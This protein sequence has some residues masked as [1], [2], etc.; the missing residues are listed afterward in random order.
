MMKYFLDIS[1][2]KRNKNFGLLYSGQFISFIG[3]KI[4]DVALPYQIY[5]QTHSTLMVGLLSL[6]QLVPLLFTALIGGVLADRYHRR[7]LL[8]ASETILCIGSLTLAWNA[9]LHSPQ[10]WV[11]FIVS[12]LMSAFNGLHRPALESML[13]QIVRKEDYISLSALRSFQGNVGMIGGPAIGGLLIA[14][15]GI[16]V[17]YLTDVLSFAFSLGSLL[18]MTEIPKPA[19]KRDESTWAALKQGC[20]FAISHQAILGSYIVDIIAMIFGMPMALFP[21]IAL[22]FGGAQALGFLYTAPAIG[23]L[24]ISFFSGWA[25]TIKHHGI[26]I[27]VA[28]SLWGIAIIFFGLANNFWLAIFFLALAGAFDAISGIFRM[29]LWSEAIPDHLRGRLAGINMISYLSGP[30]LGDVEAGLVAS[31]FGITASVVSGGV[32]CVVGVVVSCFLMPKFWSYKSA[33]INQDT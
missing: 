2:I 29:T 21:A 11:L 13:P 5:M 17:T 6:M 15:A 1:L 33:V 30:K 14:H 3:S 4:T 12:A 23:A 18:L 25:E 16:V 19:G 24:F 9:H 31:V 10:V 8:L 28:A 32:L 22:S 20:Q 26:A 27:A 7:N